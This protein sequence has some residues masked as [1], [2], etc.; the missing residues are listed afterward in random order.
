MQ[1]IKSILDPLKGDFLSELFDLL[2]FKSISTQDSHK[3]DILACAEFVNTKFKSLGL[4]SEL[5]QTKGHP[6]VFAQTKIDPN[7]KTVLVYGHYDVQPSDPDELWTSDAFEPV[8][9]DGY[10][11]ARGASDDKGQFFAH[12]CALAVLQKMGDLPV[13]LKFLIEGEEEISSP[14]IEDFLDKHLDKLDCDVVLVSDTPMYDENTPSICYSLRGM[15]YTELTVKGPNKDL[16]SGQLGGVVQNPVN[17]LAHII[18]KLKD[19]KN[20]VLIPGFYDD[21]PDLTERELGFLER[22]KNN[23]DD[24]C[25]DLGIARLVCSDGFDSNACR[26]FRPTLDCNGIVGGYIHEGAKTIIPSRVSSK[27]SMRLVGHQD[28]HK[29]FKLFSEY[30]NSITPEGVEVNIDLLST[31]YPYYLDPSNAYL[32]KALTAVEHAFEKKGVLQGE[33]GSIPIMSDFKKKLGVD[34]I[35]MGFNLPTD[36]IHSPN[37]RFLE[38]SFYRG[39]MASCLFLN[40]L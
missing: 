40:S 2:R 12:V 15:V 25:D 35:L 16:H 6:L 3:P 37:E 5:F 33:G 20:Q 22:C 7:K 18:A 32:E 8:I 19:E 14:N 38:E 10:I 23:D 21:V 28:P 34:T 4:E 24:I 9:R 39:I 17:A 29:I 11:Y 1:T 13:N 36:N 31:G 27:I 30:V 26:W